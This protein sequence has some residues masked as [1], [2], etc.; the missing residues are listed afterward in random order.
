MLPEESWAARVATDD[1]RRAKVAF[2][3]FRLQGLRS[4]ACYSPP[5]GRYP[6]RRGQEF[7]RVVTEAGFS[8]AMYTPPR[9]RQSSGWLADYERAS[10]WLGQLV[11]PVAVFASDAYPARHLAEVCQRDGVRIPDEV[12]LLAGDTD[13]LLCSVAWP[14]ISSVQLASHRIGREACRLLEL[15]MAGAEVPEMPLL[16]PPI[17]VIERHSTAVVGVIDSEMTPILRVIRDRATQG[18]EVKDLLREFPISRRCLELRCRQLIGRTPAAEI[19]RVRLVRARQLL[20]E[21][22]Q[23]IDSIAHAV[24]LSGGPVLSHLFR[25][26]LG[27]TPGALREEVRGGTEARHGAPGG[28]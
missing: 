17:G 10:R 25:K 23:S 12:A 3:H 19:R 6:D 8:C 4:F 1:A 20:V 2:E 21:T 22:E 28:R 5:I 14:Q 15:L 11:K 9:S 27:L 13:E 7:D 18:L 26:H 24:G 16:I